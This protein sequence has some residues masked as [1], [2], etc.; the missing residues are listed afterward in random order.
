MSDA[1]LTRRL[2]SVVRIRLDEA[3]CD[4]VHDD[5][6]TRG[7]RWSLQTLLVAVTTAMLTGARSLADAERVTDPRSPA[8]RR[9]L[10][11]RLWIAA[12]TPP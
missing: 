4:Q 8:A 3:A 11:I 12:R 9:W 1:R 6:S 10:G 7:R 5:R 2:A